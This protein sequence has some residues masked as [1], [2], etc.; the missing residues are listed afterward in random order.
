MGISASNDGFDHGKIP[1]PGSIDDNAGR[2][3]TINSINGCDGTFYIAA[4]HNTGAGGTDAFGHDYVDLYKLV[5]TNDGVPNRMKFVKMYRKHFEL[6][7]DNASFQ[8]A[9]GFY[10]SPAGK[11]MMYVSPGYLQ[12]RMNSA[13]WLPFREFTAP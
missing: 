11:I 1:A 8:G 6:D 3:Q 12:N 9:S 2:Y 7:H 10:V 5:P 4:T 13:K